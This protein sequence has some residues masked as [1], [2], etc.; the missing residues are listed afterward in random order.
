LP[1]DALRKEEYLLLRKVN[2]R[3]IRCRLF[4]RLTKYIGEVGKTKTRKYMDQDYWA[5]PVPTFGDPQAKLLIIGLAPAANGGNRTGRIFTGI[6]Q[7]I[8][9]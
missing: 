3:I 8:G 4:P 5:K 7:A 9:L 6:A 2:E 1:S